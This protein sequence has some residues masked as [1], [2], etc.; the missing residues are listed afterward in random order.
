MYIIAIC[1]IDNSSPY[2]E[3]VKIIMIME[4]SS[5]EEFV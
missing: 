2:S 3:E 4:K 5:L 1:R